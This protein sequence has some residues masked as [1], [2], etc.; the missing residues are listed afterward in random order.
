MPAVLLED[1][2]ENPIDPV[3]AFIYGPPKPPGFV[4]PDKP[5]TPTTIEAGFEQENPASAARIHQQFILDLQAASDDPES[6]IRPDYKQ[7]P[8]FNV[9]DYIPPE[10]INFAHVYAEWAHS[11]EEAQ[12]VKEKLDREI[13][14]DRVLSESGIAGALS[15]VFGAIASPTMLIP[16]IIVWKAAKFGPLV[17]RA[18]TA[19]TGAGLIGGTIALEELALQESQLTRTIE[20]SNI[21]VTAGLIMGGGFGWLFGTASREVLDAAEFE[22]RQALRGETKR[23]LIKKDRISIDPKTYKATFH[24][25]DCP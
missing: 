22:M 14:T 13:E 17:N 12:V 15:R 7:N 19:F 24:K 18:A 23:F 16:G 2:Q 21:A 25:L 5:L 8:D 9:I 10:H 1:I 4:D 3:H 20:E 6:E 11:P